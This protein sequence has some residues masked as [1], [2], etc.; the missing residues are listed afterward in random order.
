[1]PD[2]D[3]MPGYLGASWRKVHRCLQ[4][5]E[6]MERTADTVSAALAAT[7]RA[8]HGVPRLAGIAAQMREAAAG[9]APAQSGVP[10]SDEARRHV[11]TDI[12]E[13]A[14]GC[15]AATMP[16]VLALV[17][18]EEASLILAERLLADLAYH[19]G[20]DR[21]APLLAAE[22]TS[23]WARKLWLR[24]PVREPELWARH[25]DLLAELVEWLT[26]DIWDMEF[27]QLLDGAGPLDERQGFLFDTVPAGSVPVL[28]SGGLDSAAGLAAHLTHSDAVAISVDTNNWMQHVQQVVLQSLGVVSPHSCMPLRYRVSVRTNSVESTQRSRGLLF[29]A[30]GIATAWTVNEDRLVVFENGIG[31][32]NLP[33]LRS[34][35]GSQATRSMHPRTLRLAERLAAA[36]NRRPFRIE[37]PALTL[38]KA[39]AIQN[40]PAAADPALALT[41]SCDTG[42]SARVR[43]RAPCGRCTSCLLRRQALIAVGRADLDA[44]AHYRMKSPANT[45]ELHAMQW[46]VARLQACLDQPEP[47]PSLVTQYPDVLDTAPLTPEQVINLYR[48]Y[49]Q[50]W[51]GL[52]GTPGIGGQLCQGRTAAL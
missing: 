28:F 40:A 20:L 42:F 8:T 10:G 7:L 33:Y 43:N 39:Q 44:E 2:D 48:S 46:Q 18:P 15:L 31:A 12:A 45:P 17:S 38:T 26:D 13:Q 1:M 36:V 3:R 21:I 24:V 19:Y 14:A 25:G 6:P 11:P 29:L 34:Q 51:D 23:T 50:E 35:F 16:E 49:V 37:A 47:W 41:V 9:G 22:G 4:G 27:G 30:V 5:R 32:I 52:R